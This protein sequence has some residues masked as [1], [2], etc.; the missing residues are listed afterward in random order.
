MSDKPASSG[1]KAPNPL[2]RLA[3]SLRDIHRRHRERRRPTGFG[4]VFADRVDYLD[5]KRWDAVTDQASSFLRRD[6]LRIIEN[7]CPENIHSRYAMVFEGE[8]PVAALAAQIVSVTG[9]R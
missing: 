5:A 7:H 2:H 8:R 3:S 1:R 6:I 9:D 4:F